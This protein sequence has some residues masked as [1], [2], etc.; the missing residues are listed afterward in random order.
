MAIDKISKDRQKE[1]EQMQNVLLLLNHLVENEETTLKLIIG[2][3]YDVG[4]VNLINQKVTGERQNRVAR[5]LAGMSKPAAKVLALRWFKKNCPT[6]IVNWLQSKVSLRP[7]P[8]PEPVPSVAEV[9]SSDN[10]EAAL[11]QKSAIPRSQVREIKQLRS[12]IKILSGLLLCTMTALGGTAVWQ[13]YQ[14]SLES[15]TA[16]P[17][18]QPV[19]TSPNE[20]IQ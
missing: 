20:Q 16:K 1:A 12:Q 9:V 5:T 13:V 3:L 2:C 6:L 10:S 19:T 4:A 17:E 15:S 11:L 14:V 18:L 7:D 8:D